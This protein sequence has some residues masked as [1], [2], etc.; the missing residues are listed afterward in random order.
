MEEAQHRAVDEAD[1]AGRKA[2]A[3]GLAQAHRPKAGQGHGGSTGR[4]CST[5][6]ARDRDRR[7]ALHG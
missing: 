7:D 1:S 6:P 4:R 2:Q 5:C 3:K